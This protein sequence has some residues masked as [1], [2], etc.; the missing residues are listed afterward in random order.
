[1]LLARGDLLPRE[2][3]NWNSQAVFGGGKYTADE[4]FCDVHDPARRQPGKTSQAFGSHF[5]LVINA[6]HLQ[7][8]G[9]GPTHSDNPMAR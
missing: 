8:Q 7:L 6:V 5:S 2:R 3:D 9:Q 4:T 1:M